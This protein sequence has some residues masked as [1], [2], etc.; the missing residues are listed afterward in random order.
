MVVSSS[1]HYRPKSLISNICKLLEYIVRDS[2]EY[3]QLKTL[4]TPSQHGF[5]QNKSFLTNLLETLD[6]ITDSI[7]KGASVDLVLVDFA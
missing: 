3:L 5:V 4:I 6:I 2:M 1:Q 7:N